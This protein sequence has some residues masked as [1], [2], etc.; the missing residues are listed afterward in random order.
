MISI[1][2]LLIAIRKNC[3]LCS[4]GIQSEISECKMKD[5]PLYPYRMGLQGLD[6]VK[7]KEK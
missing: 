6:K 1:R 4:C 5:C 7:E 3:L 2:K